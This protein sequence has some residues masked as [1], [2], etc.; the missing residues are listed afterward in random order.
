L[1]LVLLVI[2]L[3]HLI[4]L[5]NSGSLSSVSSSVKTL[6]RPWYLIKDLLNLVVLILF[7]C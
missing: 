4:F 6:F 5:H 1:P 2:I 7:F 3:V